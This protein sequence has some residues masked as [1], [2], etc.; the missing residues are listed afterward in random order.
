MLSQNWNVH[1]PSIDNKTD[2]VW[3]LL[4]DE[5]A[6]S[7][8]LDATD[9]VTLILILGHADTVRI[10]AR[11]VRPEPKDHNTSVSVETV[12]TSFL[13]LPCQIHMESSG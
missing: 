2:P 12:M 7:I 10:N 5:Q 4:Y 8:V 11:R 6:S 3:R 9:E 1:R 13:L